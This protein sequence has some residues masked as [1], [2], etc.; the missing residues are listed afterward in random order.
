MTHGHIAADKV[1]IS[2]VIPRDLKEELEK[3]AAA[4]QRSMSN[5]IVRILTEA[6]A[7]KQQNPGQ[8]TR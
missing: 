6:A 5:Y 8:E 7:A 1:R 4:D 3:A 2:L